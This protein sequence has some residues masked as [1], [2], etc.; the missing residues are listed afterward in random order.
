MHIYK[1]GNFSF[2]VFYS[3][4][5]MWYI[6]TIFYC[7]L[8][9]LESSIV[10]A[11]NIEEEFRMVDTDGDSFLSLAE[12]QLLLNE[13]D[14]DES[15][16]ID[17]SE[18]LPDSSD[19]YVEKIYEAFR[20]YDKDGNSIISRADLQAV[21]DEV[22]TDGSGSI[23]LAE[24]LVY[25]NGNYSGIEEMMRKIFHMHDED[26]NG[27]ISEDELYAIDADGNGSVDLE[28]F[29]VHR[30]GEIFYL[31]DQDDDGLISQ[32]D[33]SYWFY[34]TAT[35]SRGISL[36]EFMASYMIDFAIISS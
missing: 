33:L 31:E 7:A 19:L 3:T 36:P 24:F 6:A 14:A 8:Y 1:T 22:D 28:E 11:N 30:I 23:D 5:K 13:S 34:E 35:D 9:I 17:F 20:R 12:L 26:G 18:Y 10:K 2:R 25:R 27:V 29:V 15:G 32:T 16:A 4:E 21:L